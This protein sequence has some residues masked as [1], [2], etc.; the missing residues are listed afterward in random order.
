MC[1]ISGLISRHGIT[2]DD[3]ARVAAMSRALVHRGPDDGGEYRARH[4]AMAA[5]RLSIIDLE[6]GAQPL[7]NEDRTLALVA[8]GEIYN[9]IELRRRLLALGHRF[10]TGSDC[11]TILHAYAEYGLACVDHLR[12]M[13]AFALWDSVRQRLL[14]A[15]DP[16]GE[17][18]LYLYEREGR[19]LFAS[20]MKALL[21]SGEVPFELD[22]EAVNL[23]F[24]Y[25]YV[26]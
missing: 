19:L 14:L 13:F 22:P 1:G 11:E 6:G 4:V 9:H 8:N 26:P 7:Y 16:L 2:G 25:Q 17:K 5:R 3:A 24:H 12:G 23:Y 18:P 20:E 10:S 15:R 21:R